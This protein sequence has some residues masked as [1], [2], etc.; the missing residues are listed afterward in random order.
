MPKNNYSLDTVYNVGFD[1]GYEA[2]QRD[3]AAEIFDE[4]EDILDRCARDNGDMICRTLKE[5]SKKYEERLL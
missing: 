5:L 1:K 4:I 3:M 2:G